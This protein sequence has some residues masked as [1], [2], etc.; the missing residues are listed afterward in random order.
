M[1]GMFIQQKQY[2]P[3]TLAFKVNGTNASNVYMCTSKKTHC[4]RNF[5][6]G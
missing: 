4:P 1:Q 5:A 3:T 6:D 2:N